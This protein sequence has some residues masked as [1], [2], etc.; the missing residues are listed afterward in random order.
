MPEVKLSVPARPDYVHVLRQVT[1]GVA[2]RLRFSYD[3]IED[4]R[5][6]IGE[7]CAYLLGVRPSATALTLLVTSDEPTA[8]IE[9]V[10]IATGSDSTPGEGS[11]Q[12]GIIWHILGALTDDAHFEQLPEGPGIRFTKAHSVESTQG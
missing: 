2:A 8:R 10:T 7:A 5:L 4:L 9:A 6:A 12:E 11:P 1:A 3:E